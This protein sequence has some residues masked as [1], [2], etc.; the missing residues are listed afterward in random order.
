MKKK[1]PTKPNKLTEAELKRRYRKYFLN[2]RCGIN[3]ILELPELTQQ[4]IWFCVLQECLYTSSTAP[5]LSEMYKQNLYDEDDELKDV[6]LAPLNRKRLFDGISDLIVGNG[7]KKFDGV[8]SNIE[9]SIT[10]GE[11]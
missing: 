4:Y 9:Q 3:K 7:Q 8:L 1:K 2:I 5:F 10:T 6:E 11:Y